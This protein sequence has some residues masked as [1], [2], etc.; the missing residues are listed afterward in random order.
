MVQ[1]ASQYYIQQLGGVG[2][3]FYKFNKGFLHQKVQLIDENISMVGTANYDNRSFRLNF[4]LTM[5][6]VDEAFA[7]QVEQM[8]EDDMSH[9]LILDVEEL[10]SQSFWHQVPRRVARLFAPAL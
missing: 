5:L 8:L 1:Q 3:K 10:N 7:T 6:I 9:S 4:E 2:I